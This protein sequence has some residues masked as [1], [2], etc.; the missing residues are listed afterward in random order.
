MNAQGSQMQPDSF[1][2][3]VAASLPRSIHTHLHTWA[4]RVRIVPVN[5]ISVLLRR[6]RSRNNN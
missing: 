5:L 6:F 1:S 3:P 2:V 4:D